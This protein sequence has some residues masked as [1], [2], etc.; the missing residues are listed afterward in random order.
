[1]HESIF[2][3]YRLRYPF[4]TIYIFKCITSLMIQKKTEC[5]KTLSSL[6]NFTCNLAQK[7][8]TSCALPTFIFPQCNVFQFF[9]LL[10]WGC[11]PP[12]Y[13]DVLSLTQQ[14]FSRAIL[15]V[16]CRSKT[17]ENCSIFSERMIVVCD[18]VALCR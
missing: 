17:I 3:L 4:V 5:A 15:F 14:F 2:F 7:I 12:H 10:F 13:P 6:S 16:L 18:I 9:L 1:M 8:T 11:F